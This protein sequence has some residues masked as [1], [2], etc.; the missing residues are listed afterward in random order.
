MVMQNRCHPYVHQNQ[1]AGFIACERMVM[2]SLPQASSQAH[3]KHRS[4]IAPGRNL[5]QELGLVATKACEDSVE[6]RKA[7][8]S[9][10]G[11]FSLFKFDADHA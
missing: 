5:A 6:S 3:F 8:A 1:K 11:L 10:G 2:R 9:E 4:L 7:H